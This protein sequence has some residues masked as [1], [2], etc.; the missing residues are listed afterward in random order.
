VPVRDRQVLHPVAAPDT[1]V[2][3]DDVQPTVESHDAVEDLCHLLGIAD[4]GLPRGGSASHR[5]HHSRRSIRIRAIDD[6]DLRPKRCQSTSDPRTEPSRAAGD[7]RDL[8]GKG[9]PARIPIW[10][11]PSIACTVR[12]VQ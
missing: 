3:D 9:L 1:G 4:V 11:W 2:R 5:L 6:R 8:P 7:E 12:S 10:H